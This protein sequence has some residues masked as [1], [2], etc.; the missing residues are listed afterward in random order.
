MKNDS[1]DR[2]LVI[3]DEDAVA[4]LA[5]WAPAAVVSAVIAGFIGLSYYAY[6]AGTQS[7]KEEDLVVVEADKTPLKEKPLDPGG[8]K[9]PN[10]DKTIF[11]T[12][13]NNPQQPAKVER[14]LPRPEEPISKDVDTSTASTWINEKLHNNAKVAPTEGKETVVGDEDAKPQEKPAEAQTAQVAPA[15]GDK[16]Q[17]IAAE[18]PQDEEQSETFVAHKTPQK[19]EPKKAEPEP[20]KA[21][22]ELDKQIEK[23]KADKPKEEKPKPEKFQPEKAKQADSS[24]GAVVQ[25]GAYRSEQELNDAWEKMHIKFKE[26]SDKRPVIMRADL[27]AKGIYYRLRVTGIAS[28]ADAKSLCDTLSSKGQP[29]IIPVGK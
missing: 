16:H 24:G 20:K 26:L 1:H 29:C 10:Q 2:N 14:V 15:S 5:R 19:T 25:L 21:E 13:A 22:V 17:V 23:P 8:M 27:G 4:G 6:H 3:V 12:F 18:A 9:F 28:A 11:E 7:V